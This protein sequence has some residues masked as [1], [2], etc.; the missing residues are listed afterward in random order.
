MVKATLWYSHEIFQG[1]QTVTEPIRGDQKQLRSRSRLVR[2]ELLIDGLRSAGHEQKRHR[3]G[4][5]AIPGW[6][7]RNTA[8]FRIQQSSHERRKGDFAVSWRDRLPREDTGA[9]KTAGFAWRR[10]RPD[11]PGPLTSLKQFSISTTLHSRPASRCW[12]L[13]LLLAAWY[14]NQL[15]PT[16]TGFTSKSAGEMAMRGAVA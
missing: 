9:E 8:P 7:G 13:A 15:T 6:T 2:R 11:S 10:L 14:V 4:F 3:S 12:L 16:T 1:L 5:F